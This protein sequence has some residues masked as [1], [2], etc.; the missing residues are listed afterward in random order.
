VQKRNGA[1]VHNARRGAGKVGVVTFYDAAVFIMPF[2][3]YQ[4]R[5]LDDIASSN[6]GLRYLDWLFGEGKDIT[7][8]WHAAVATYLADPSIKKELESL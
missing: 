8:P 1:V 5:K 3:K 7:K 2:G 6:E 4:G